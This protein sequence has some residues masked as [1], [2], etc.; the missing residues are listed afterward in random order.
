MEHN[1][2]ESKSKV[3]YQENLSELL[4]D[5]SLDTFKKAIFHDCY[6]TDEK[7]GESDQDTKI[8]FFELNDIMECPLESHEN[9]TCL[10][11][12]LDKLTFE[13]HIDGSVFSATQFF[14]LDLEDIHGWIEDSKYPEVSEAW[15]DY[16][17]DTLCTSISSNIAILKESSVH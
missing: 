11:V 5:L 16:L 1:L 17:K 4:K 13:I 7:F 14:M 15:Y 8:I 10:I 3:F 12:E 2:N 9:M 6:I